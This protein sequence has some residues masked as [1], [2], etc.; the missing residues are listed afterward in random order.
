[1]KF[2]KKKSETPRRHAHDTPETQE[3]H[4]KRATPK[5]APKIAEA[6]K[7]EKTEVVER[8]TWGDCLFQNK[9][10]KQAALKQFWTANHLPDKA[11]QILRGTS[12]DAT[13]AD[14]TYGLFWHPTK[15]NLQ[16]R[17]QGDDKGYIPP[18]HREVYDKL[19][20]QLGK[21]HLI[22]VRKAMVALHLRSGEG[23]Y[24]LI[25][26]VKPESPN[27]W[28]EIN[29]FSEWI[30]REMPEV[31]GCYVAQGKESPFRFGETRGIQLKKEFGPDTLHS[32]VGDRRHFFH[33]L[34]VQDADR[35]LIPT[36]IEIAKQMV[37]PNKEQ[38][39]LVMNASCPAF[40]MDFANE[41]KTVHV[42]DANPL[43]RESYAKN[44]ERHEWKNVRFSKFDEDKDWAR[45]PTSNAVV[46]A[47]HLPLNMDQIDNLVGTGA[48]RIVRR[49]RSPEEMGREWG[50]WRRAGW[51]LYR[52]KV[53]DMNPSHSERLELWALF[54]KDHRGIL[55]IT[56]NAKKEKYREEFHNERKQNEDFYGRGSR[57][58]GRTRSSR[59][60]APRQRADGP[61]NRP[62][63]PAPRQSSFPKF[64]Q[65]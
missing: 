32:Q 28:R 6:P 21:E 40:V 9:G 58:E 52:L 55:Q 5:P 16:T 33:P 15:R 46:C 63:A 1:M 11:P 44:R 45:L 60:E 43:A 22:R 30:Q 39:A 24:F 19:V 18:A 13:P 12:P 27:T 25:L 65:K 41:C 36:T 7:L 31:Q 2:Q 59:P 4:V 50:K 17:R 42:V 37:K 49:F 3:R 48:E 54:Q 57:A 61:R 20:A 26:Q 23:V 64:V 38:S 47:W 53:L 29:R 8:L 34:D 10:D 56:K 35:S 62:D 14:S 51:V